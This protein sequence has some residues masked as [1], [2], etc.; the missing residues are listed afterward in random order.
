MSARPVHPPLDSGGCAATTLIVA[1][2]S[3]TAVADVRGQALTPLPLRQGEIAFALRAT[4]VSDF[5]GQVSALHAEF[6][7]E[8]LGD[9]RGA[10]EFRVADMHTGIGLRDTHMRNAMSA[11]SFPTIR[12]DLAGI[13]RGASSGDTI[14][15]VFHGRLTI[16][17]VTKAVTVP[18]S[19]VLHPGS[20]DVTASTPIDMTEYGIEP[21]TRFLGAI[22]VKP[23]TTVTATLSFGRN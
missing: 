20:V 22:R 10:L 23:V 18:G 13:D 21:P 19:V 7:G 1:I 14:Q 15:V 3:L 11:D 4:K 6:E 16:R 5:V 17:G 9:I 8:D 2:L 12:F